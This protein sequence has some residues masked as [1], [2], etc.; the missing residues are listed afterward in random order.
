MN[1]IESASCY[2]QQSSVGERE[3]QGQLEQPPHNKRLLA[4]VRQ[5]THLAPRLSCWA[6]N[7]KQRFHVHA[8]QKDFPCYCF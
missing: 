8:T 7:L 1:T 3:Y 2:P 5:T 6:W 4:N